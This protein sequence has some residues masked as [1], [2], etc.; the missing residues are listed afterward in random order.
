MFA[1][2]RESVIKSYIIFSNTQ[3]EQMTDTQSILIYTGYSV[4][5]DSSH[6][7]SQFIT[8][9]SHNCCTIHYKS[10]FDKTH[11]GQKYLNIIQLVM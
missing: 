8:N 7:R 4:A 10:I 5:N 9:K 2:G 11:T 3:N 1:K 6:R